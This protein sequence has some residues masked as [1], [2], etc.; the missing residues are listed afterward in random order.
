MRIKQLT[1]KKKSSYVYVHV[2]KAH[3]QTVTLL[4]A[5]FHSIV[6]SIYIL[7]YYSI[8]TFAFLHEAC[9][10]GVQR[11]KLPNKLLDTIIAI[12]TQYIQHTAATIFYH[13]P[14]RQPDK[15]L[16]PK[17]EKSQSENGLKNYVVGDD[18]ECKL[19]A[20]NN[21]SMPKNEK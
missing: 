4:I 1:R 2:C 18:D 8:F 17:E 11:R 10:F 13:N 20:R 14:P 16:T 9:T 21:C 7:H 3:L 6:I 12:N 19:M 15:F 5:S